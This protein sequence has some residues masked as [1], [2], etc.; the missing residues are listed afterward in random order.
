MYSLTFC[1]K[2]D[3]SD[4]VAQGRLGSRSFLAQEILLLCQEDFS[5]PSS[6]IGQNCDAFE[7]NTKGYFCRN[8]YQLWFLL[9]DVVKY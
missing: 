7:M 4:F 5:K 9:W 3:V 1:L 6:L 8:I 2:F